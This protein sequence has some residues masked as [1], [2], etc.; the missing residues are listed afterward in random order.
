MFHASHTMEAL[1]QET[2]SGDCSL[3]DDGTLQHLIHHVLF[4]NIVILRTK[5]RHAASALVTAAKTHVQ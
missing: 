5:H 4:V 2:D 3:I 1:E